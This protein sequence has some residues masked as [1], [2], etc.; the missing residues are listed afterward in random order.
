MKL[1]EVRAKKLMTAKELADRSGVSEV[2]IYKLEKGAWL[3]SLPTVRKLSD[4]LGLTS[5]EEV[6]E[7]RKAID[8]AAKRGS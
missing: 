4:A 8:K 7:F 1:R 3:P 6:E 5:P 2:L